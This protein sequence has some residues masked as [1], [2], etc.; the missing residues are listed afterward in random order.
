MYIKLASL[1]LMQT[2]SPSGF[3]RIANSRAGNVEVT[4][5]EE[6]IFNS[7]PIAPRSPVHRLVRLRVQRMALKMFE[8]VP[9]C[10][11]SVDDFP[12]HLSGLS[13]KQAAHQA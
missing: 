4:G 6:K 12:K 5:A 3:A 9:E 1:K 13:C 8:L 7:K 2:A 11:I 10:P